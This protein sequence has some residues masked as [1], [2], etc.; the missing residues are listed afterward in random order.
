MYWITYAVHGHDYAN[1]R[2]G[3]YGFGMTLLF[4]LTLYGWYF[5]A[6]IPGVMWR[7]ARKD[8]KQKNQEISEKNSDQNQ[9]LN[10]R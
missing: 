1:T 5:L 6:A 9:K 2:Y 4:Y 7:I 8:N 10:T 3:S